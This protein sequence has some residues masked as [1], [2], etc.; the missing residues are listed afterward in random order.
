MRV[1]LSASLIL[2]A[3]VLGCGERAPAASESAEPAASPP[4]A[5]PAE[6]SK[7][8]PAKPDPAKAEPPKLLSVQRG[9]EM[10]GTMIQMTAIGLTEERAAPALEAA[11]R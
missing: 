2:L 8:E 10:M 6:P 4:P 1:W 3:S 5:K 11:W 9:R 7:P